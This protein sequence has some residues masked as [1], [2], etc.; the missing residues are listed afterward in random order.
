MVLVYHEIKKIII[1]KMFRKY[2][3]KN[4]VQS[5]LKRRPSALPIK[6][7]VLARVVFVAIAVNCE[8]LITKAAF[9]SI[10]ISP[11]I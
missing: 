10:A 4:C 7:T 2:L 9:D 11:P 1:K 6:A 8:S 3:G 5:T